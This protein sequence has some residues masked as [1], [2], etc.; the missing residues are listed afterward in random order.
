MCSLTALCPI[1]SNACKYSGAKPSLSFKKQRFK[2]LIV[3][4]NMASFEAIQG[5]QFHQGWAVYRIKVISG[6]LKEKDTC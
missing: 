2:K 6:Y 4:S 1:T 3:Q 5:W